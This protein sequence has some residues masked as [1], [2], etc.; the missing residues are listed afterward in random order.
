MTASDQDLRVATRTITTPFLAGF[1]HP[2]VS[3]NKRTGFV[4]GVLFLELNGFK[5]VASEED[6]TQAV[7]SLA[8]G[9][10]D[11]TIL[12]AWLRANSKPTRR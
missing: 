3:G 8:A 12:T 5:F 10:L 9:K 11:E 7:F 6:A 1:S 4:L 2:F